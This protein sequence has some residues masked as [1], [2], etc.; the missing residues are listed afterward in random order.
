[1]TIGA[2]PDLTITAA[3]WSVPEA[4]RAEALATRPLLVLMHGRGSHER[5]LASLIPLLPT[6]SVVVSLRAPI[7]MGDGFSWFPPAEPGLPDPTD[8][9][10]ATDAVLAFL[11][12]LPTTGQVGLL[13]FSQGGAM[14]TQLVRFA[15]ERFAAGV[16]LSGFVLAGEL[17]GDAALAT[18][19]P[20]LFW[21]RDVADPVIVQSAID[22]TAAWVSTH[23][24]AVVREYPGVAHSISR[25]ELD[26][27]SEFLV[28]TVL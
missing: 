21:G 27:V 20:P 12:A 6:E 19:R 10:A 28:A 23:T 13:G 16:V 24:T 7:P 11:D 26:D 2:R 9:A 1:M 14:V 25:E 22:R 15:P 17:P 18:L 3:V 4:E 8:A 5:D